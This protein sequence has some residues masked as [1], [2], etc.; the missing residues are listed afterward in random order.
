MNFSGYFGLGVTQSQL[1]FVDIPLETDIPLFIDPFA[2]SLN[3]DRFSINSHNIVCSFFQTVIDLIKNNNDNEAFYLLS[4]LKEPN[5]THLGLSENDP[6]GSGIGGGT[7]SNLFDALKESSAVKT[8]FINSLEESELMIDGISKDRISD[9]TTNIIR[10]ELLQYTKNQCKNWNI[11]TQNVSVGFV[12]DTERVRWIPKYSEVPVVENKFILLVPKFIVRYDMAYDSNKYY[13]GFVLDYLQSDEINKGSSLVHTFKSGKRRGQKHVTKKSLIEIYPKTK[14]YLYEFS[15]EH[16]EVL[17]KYKTTMEE[18]FKEGKFAFENDDNEVLVSE[19]LIDALNHIQ[20][21]K[22][23]AT[24]YH[25]AM[26]GISE[27]IFYPYLV[28]PTVEEPI[29]QGRKRIDIVM[30]N[31]AKDGIFYELSR[32]ANFPCP[33]IVIECKNYT[34]DINNPEL[35]Q[36]SG[37]FSRDRGRVG[38]SCSRHI[39]NKEAIYKRCNDTL[40]D[41]RGLILAL[42]DQD[43]TIMLDNIRNNRRSVNDAY[44]RNLRKKIFGFSR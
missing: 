20:T 22:D 37:R 21:G 32:S 5:E 28:N 39:Q 12:Y 4:K 30:D 14:N 17:E 6:H 40:A 25:K 11:P 41:G 44:L 35:D 16:P 2:L 43:I 27:F 19:M 7:S 24:E 36:L 10:D 31:A 9:L 23:S 38:I 13:R 26:T 15:K 33:F 34:E 1:D 42:D 18:V 8:G 29:H 3:S